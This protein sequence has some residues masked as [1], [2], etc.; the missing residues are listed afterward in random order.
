MNKL[1]NVKKR[2]TKELKSLAKYYKKSGRPWVVSRGFTP[3]ASSTTS[4]AR[5]RK[6]TASV[7]PSLNS[8][9]NIAL[10]VLDVEEEHEKQ[11]STDS[12]V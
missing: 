4:F 3:P 5:I 8:H 9:Q 11:R 12:Q 1:K 2:H 10:Q 6:M 7:A